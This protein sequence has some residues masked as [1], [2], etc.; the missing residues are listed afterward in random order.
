MKCMN[1]G[2]EMPEEAKYCAKCAKPLVENLEMKDKQAI[3]KGKNS[4]NDLKGEDTKNKKQQKA[5]GIAGLVLG[6]ISLFLASSGSAFLGV[7]GIIICIFAIKKE[8]KKGKA[9]A[10]LVC[11]ILALVVAVCVSVTP[12]N[13]NVKKENGNAIEVMED[14]YEFFTSDTEESEET[15]KTTPEVT[16][17]PEEIKKK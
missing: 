4:R 12:D 17:S 2:A 15:E 9:I 10:G 16:M 6:I 8:E 7:V 5:F 14:F 11:S 13:A 1:C 3:I